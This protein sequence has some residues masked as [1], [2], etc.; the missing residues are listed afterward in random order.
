MSEALEYRGRRLPWLNIVRFHKEIASRGEESLFSFNGDAQSERWTSL[1]GFSLVSLSGPWSVSS[2]AIR[3]G[4]FRLACEQGQHQSLFIGGP[5]Y[6]G[7]ERIDNSWHPRWRPLLYRQIEL[8]TEDEIIRAVPNQAHWQV[9]PL[10]LALLDRLQVLPAESERFAD[11]IIDRAGM[12]LTAGAAPTTSDAVLAALFQLAPEIET[13]LTHPLRAGDFHDQPTAWVLFAP[14]NRFSILNRYLMSDY[15]QL[16]ARL[17][18]DLTECGGLR[19]LEDAQAPTPHDESEPVPFVPLNATQR[20][21]VKAALGDAPLTVIS[22]PPGCGKSQVVI[23]LLL[24]CWASGRSA[25]FASNNNKAV[26]VVRERLERFESEFPIAVRA[27]ARKYNNAAN[28]LRRTLNMAGAARRKEAIADPVR[29]RAGLEKVQEEKRRLKE[30]LESG[31]P[32]R[33]DEAARAALTAYS[34]Y[35]QILVALAAQEDGLLKALRELGLGT[36]NPDEVVRGADAWMSWQERLVA[37]ALQCER[38]EVQARTLHREMQ[39]RVQTVRQTLAT[40]GVDAGADH[41][42]WLLD[43]AQPELM[44]EWWRSARSVLD[45]PLDGA[46][47]NVAWDPDFEQWRSAAD[48]SA[49]L[50]AARALMDDIPA[51]QVGLDASTRTLRLVEEGLEAARGRANV[52]GIP[53]GV[54]VRL[55][56][57][58]EWLECWAERCSLEKGLLD[59]LPWS[60]KQQL[61]RTCRRLESTLRASFPI[62]V[63]TTIGTL[64]DSGRQKLAT[65]VEAARAWVEA[66]ADW[67]EHA[68]DRSEV[69]A[70]LDRLRSGATR[71]GVSV[72]AAQ[73]N[74]EV[75]SAVARELEYKAATA[76]DAALAWKHRSSK[77]E[78]QQA[79]A[80]VARGWAVTAHGN[81]AKEAWKNAFGRSLDESMQELLIHQSVDTAQVAR[82]S[83][84]EAD[85]ATLVHTW[86][87]ARD[88]CREAEQR[89]SQLA[90]LPDVK[91][92]IVDWRATRPAVAWL[93]TWEQD[94]FPTQD[95]RDD[96][97]TFECAVRAWLTRWQ[98]FANGERDEL[99]RSAE[100]ELA[101]AEERAVA[102]SQLL[103]GTAKGRAAKELV[104]RCLANREQW[105]TSELAEALRG[106]SPDVIKALCDRADAKLER[107][108]FGKAKAD[109]LERLAAD[110]VA[111]RAIDDLE[112]ALQRQNGALS[113]EQ[114]DNFREALRLIPL[115]ITTAQAAQSIPMTPDLLDLLIIDEASQCTVTNLLPLVY[116]ARKL[117]VIGDSEQL[118]A[119]PIVHPT[120]ELAIAAKYDVQEHVQSLGHA[121]ND[122]F[123]AATEA[124]PRRRGD[125]YMLMEHFRS[126]PLIIGFSNR[127][128]YG[129][130]LT[131]RKEPGGARDM[132]FGGGIHAIQVPGSA[133]RGERGRSWCNRTEDIAVIKCLR[134]IRSAAPHLSIGIVTPFSAQKELLRTSVASLDLASEVLVDTAAGFQGDE[135]DVIIF[136]PVVSRGMTRGACRWVETPPNLL[137]VALTRAREALFVVA[138]FEFCLQQEGVLRKLAEYCKEVTTLRATS[139]AE[140][141]LFS[142]MVAAG[143]TPAVH[144]RIGDHEA[145]FELKAENGIRVVVEVDGATFHAAHGERDKAIDAYL[146]GRGFRVVRVSARSVMDTP[147]TTLHRIMQALAG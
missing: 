50:D 34:S 106:F 134:D 119:I 133:S 10:V 47:V 23:S 19:L 139:P 93:P 37:C 62:E 60:R 96:W 16:E 69:L 80:A 122:V 124:L 117:V 95:A 85:L 87:G 26:D 66:R 27:G 14:A 6:R 127:H 138:D 105:P 137:N 54:D 118:S 63:W 8:V 91:S 116:R 46:L 75:W 76:E 111:V 70:R 43:G 145:D 81:P 147:Q 30:S 13:E 110:A 143:L 86:Q 35:K 113:S 129:K 92:R 5:C 40:I 4:N 24:N 55:E 142:W 140:L 3:S 109:W 97:T 112:K 121:A 82:K 73:L 103:P 88:I 78:A 48:A 7:V 71:L 21:A 100:R 51:A 33:I 41:S 36:M 56:T 94:G 126:H 130:R 107:A 53:E 128:I 18:A 22:G 9:S 74:L 99:T 77:E 59:I 20:E 141:E 131:I 65:V 90:L 83:F 12:L 28:T 57:L 31:V 52:L 2:A 72:P 146:E 44:T 89:R 125:V 11:A 135:R 144:P 101:W 68:P 29:Y 39:E 102:I 132:P 58:Q 15:E 114:T 42:H 32:Q 104:A 64:D 67:N 136:S 38:D 98:A 17:A 49:W 123:K 25:L 120:E 45:A 115:W 79:L 61:K 108:A 84:Y 1:E